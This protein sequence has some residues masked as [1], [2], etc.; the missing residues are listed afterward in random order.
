MK[1]EGLVLLIVLAV[2][3]GAFWLTLLNVLW[4]AQRRAPW[5]RTNPRVERRVFAALCVLVVVGVV[6]LL[7]YYFLRHQ[8]CTGRILIM[9]NPRG[10][11]IECVCEEGRRGVCFDPGP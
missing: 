3:G 1:I 4:R 5:R 7:S 11:P 2:V 9:A 8:P 6:L 10:A